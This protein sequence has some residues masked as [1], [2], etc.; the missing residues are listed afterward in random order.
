M[1]IYGVAAT[2]AVLLLA[3]CTAGTPAG[4]VH[5]VGT[6]TDVPF[7]PA[8]GNEILEYEGSIWYPLLPDDQKPA[9][10]DLPEPTG[11]AA[12]ASGGRGI[13]ASVHLV[14]APGPGD[15][16]GTLTIYD[17]GTAYWVSD[18]GHLDTWLTTDEIT[19]EWV[20]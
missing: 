7:Y 19:Y 2:V 14:V 6:Y 16:T 15:D 11:Q 17:D 5:K 13:S 9:P 12:G 18:N 3:G 20:C 10:T 1:R 8:C 4:E